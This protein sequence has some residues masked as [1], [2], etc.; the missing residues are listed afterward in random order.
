[1]SVDVETCPNKLGAEIK[2]AVWYPDW[3]DATDEIREALLTYVRP[4]PITVDCNVVFRRVVDTWP[5]KLGAEMNPAVWYPVWR[6]AVVET[7]F[8][9]VVAPLI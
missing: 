5:I 9:V 2:P 1:M 6:P 4:R 8:N 7:R 3:R